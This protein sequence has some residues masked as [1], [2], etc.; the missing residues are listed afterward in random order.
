MNN[1]AKSEGDVYAVIV[2]DS[3]TLLKAFSRTH[4]M[5]RRAPH[6]D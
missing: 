4:S 2:S 3:Y 6:D 5:F 1:S